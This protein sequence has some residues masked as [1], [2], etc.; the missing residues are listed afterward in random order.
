MNERTTALGNVPEEGVIVMSYFPEDPT[1]IVAGPELESEKLNAV[2]CTMKA[3][4]VLAVCEPDV[5]VTVIE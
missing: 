3:I 2:A 5:P 4:T 1:A